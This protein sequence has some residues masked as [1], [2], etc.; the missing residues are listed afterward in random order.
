[1]D[2]DAVVSGGASVSVSNQGGAPLDAVMVGVDSHKQTLCAAAANPVGRLVASMEVD[3]DDEGHRSL[4]CWAQALAPERVWAVEGSGGYGRILAATLTQVGEQVVES[5][6]HLTARGRKMARRPDKSD[7]DDA[8]AIARS[9][10]RQD[11]P[12]PPPRS[13]DV[14]VLMR[15]LVEE[16]EAI[17]AEAT[18]VRNRIHAHFVALPAG[19]T[20]QIGSLTSNKGIKAAERVRAHG[21]PFLE[22]RAAA[23]R[24]LA[25][26]LKHLRRDAKELE[27]SLRELVEGCGTTLHQLRGLGHLS[28]AK[29]LGETGDA[30]RFTNE[31]CFGRFSGTAPIEASSGQVVR[32]RLSRSGNRQVNR[33][34]HTMA[35]TQIRDD[36]RAAAFVERKQSQGSSRREA[37]RALKRHLS[38]VVYRNMIKDLKQ[39]RM[40]LDT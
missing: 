31:G 14:T 19:L 15:L 12:L 24:R 35:L 13:D 9:A 7:Q 36:P 3:N 27:V 17:E 25:R 37:V 22:A 33:V 1:V 39:G 5:P 26:R 6:A 4:L 11:K 30:R 23:V 32:H 10:L 40:T 21:D 20:R 38:N 34:L 2:L 16:R 29:L 18:R 8:L 28:A